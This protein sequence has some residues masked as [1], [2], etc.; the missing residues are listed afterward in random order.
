M[1]KIIEE[2]EGK[3]K[4]L[5]ENNILLREKISNLEVTLTKFSHDKENQ[6]RA[7]KVNNPTTSAKNIIRFIGQEAP[8]SSSLKV[9][10]EHHREQAVTTELQTANQEENGD[11]DVNITKNPNVNDSKQ[12]STQDVKKA[13]ANVKMDNIVNLANEDHDGKWE[14]QHKRKNR[15]IQPRNNTRSITKQLGTNEDDSNGFDGVG[16]K[17]WLYLYRIQTAVT[18]EKIYNYIRAKPGFNELNVDVK[19]LPTT[20]TQN[21]CFVVTAPYEK[22]TLMYDPSFWPKNV[23]IKRYDFRRQKNYNQ[24]S[25]L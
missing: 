5:E 8:I 11:V 6:P 2:L 1:F 3:N 10:A 23:G 15:K 19:E 13:I 12:I 4:Y 16:R 21:K 18:I 22:K 20:E 25:F 7:K 14:M 17:V 24:N 9:M